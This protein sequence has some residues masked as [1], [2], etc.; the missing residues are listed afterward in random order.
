MQ[1]NVLGLIGF[2]LSHS[3]SAKYFAAKF[4]KENIVGWEYKT[5]P[6]EHI[7][8][9]PELLKAEKNLRGL[10]VTIPHKESVMP[11][12]DS[13]SDAA[14]DI[15]AVN[16]IRIERIQGQIKT[17]GYNT[18]V[19]GL[20]KSLEKHKVKLQGNVLIL[21]TGGA[22]KA[23]A[24]VCRKHTQQVFFATRSKRAE[25]QITYTELAQRTL[26]DFPLII[27]CTPLGMYPNTEEM[28][29]LPY[30]TLSNQNT[31][32]DLIYNPQT[33]RFMEQ[34]IQKGCKVIGGLHML[35]QQAEAAWE[36]W[37]KEIKV[38]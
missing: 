35:E 2:P 26:S 31:L 33:T 1:E 24:W 30:A 4:D 12:L 5:F 38:S 6:L 11:L 8:D 21:G 7:Q 13:L 25:D 34:G 23:A 3:W 27:N 14:R 32:F 29:P 28:P 20:E 22:S 37:N 19:V 9:L 15:G 10:N 16:T 36:I 17:T 18:D